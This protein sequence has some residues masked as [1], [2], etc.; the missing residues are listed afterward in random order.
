M[1]PE[2]GLVSDSEPTSQA[3]SAEVSSPSQIATR[4][5]VCYKVQAESKFRF[6]VPASFEWWLTLCEQISS[7]MVS[8]NI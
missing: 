5:R 2:E 8:V 7:G 1:K 4:F 3:L 6:Q